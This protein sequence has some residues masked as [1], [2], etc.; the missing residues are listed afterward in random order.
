M[1][2]DPETPR[3]KEQPKTVETEES[4]DHTEVPQFPIVKF[5]GVPTPESQRRE[6]KSSSRRGS[7]LKN[8]STMLLDTIFEG[9][10]YD[11]TFEEV[12]KNLL[13]R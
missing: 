13:K 10:N 1:S 8:Y 11:S 6:S 2:D 9:K 4:A 5:I 7:A 3:Q 12:N